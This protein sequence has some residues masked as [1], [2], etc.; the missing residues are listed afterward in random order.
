MVPVSCV[1]IVGVFWAYWSFCFLVL[2]RSWHF[3]IRFCLVL[4][5]KKL[6]GVR[7]EEQWILVKH[8]VILWRINR[9]LRF[10]K[11]KLWK[12]LNIPKKMVVNSLFYRM[13]ERIEPWIPIYISS[14]NLCHISLSLKSPWAKPIDIYLL[15]APKQVCL[16]NNHF[17]Q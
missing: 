13:L 15:E 6:V 7:L 3:V 2:S 5:E 9:S 16:L 11:K 10:D 8:S 14:I 1:F 17:S 4:M 12:I